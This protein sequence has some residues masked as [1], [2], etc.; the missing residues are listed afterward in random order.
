MACKECLKDVYE[1]KVIEV[2]QGNCIHCQEPILLI[3]EVTLTKET[4]DT[5]SNKYKKDSEGIERYKEYVRGK[6]I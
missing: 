4:C 5:L 1:G 3:T 6:D 2:D